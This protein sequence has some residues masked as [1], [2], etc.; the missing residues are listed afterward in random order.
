[1]VD[2]KIGPSYMVGKLAGK[3]IL[4][5]A[6]INC[7]KDYAANI[8]CK[9]FGSKHMEFKQTMFNIAMAI[10]GLDKENFFKIY[11]DRIFKEKPH[12]SFLGLS[13]RNLMIWISEEVCKPKFGKEY[14]GVPAAMNLSLSKGSIF[15]DSGFPEEVAPITRA[16]GPENTYVVRFTRDNTIFESNDSRKFLKES[17]CPKGVKFLDIEN[18]GDIYEFCN[19][20]ASWV[21]EN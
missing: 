13:P 1:M 16:V 20:I 19:E 11:N 4:L 9:M 12:K 18:D 2:S 10:T 17:E 15:S 5:N 21:T 6:P 3:V 7:G 8:L 14:F